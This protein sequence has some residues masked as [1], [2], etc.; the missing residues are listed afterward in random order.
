LD[1]REENQK[2]QP[3]L[4]A[5]NQKTTRGLAAKIDPDGGL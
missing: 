2:R 5:A 1:L 4:A 3:A